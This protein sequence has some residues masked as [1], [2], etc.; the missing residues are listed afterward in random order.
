[1]SEPGHW[2]NPA[3]GAPQQQP[4]YAQAPLPQVAAP[5]TALD[6]APDYWA[7]PAPGPAKIK[8]RGTAVKVT[9]IILLCVLALVTLVTLA[10]FA[11]SIGA[12]VFLI[13]GAMALIPLAICIATL[14]WIDRWEP[15]PK[16]AL[17]LGFCW[18]AGMAVITTLVIGSWVQPLLM[19]TN[20]TADADMVGAVIQAPLVEELCK[21]AGVLLLFFLR[22]RTFDGPIDGV[23]YA[24]MIAAG[25]A[26]TENILYFGQALSESDGAVGGLVG[27]FI[28]RGLMSPFAHVMFTATLGV[29]VG[30]AARNGGT[31]M[32][33]GAWVVGLV[34]AMLLHGLW[35]GTAFLGGNFFVAYVV[36]QVPLFILSIVGIILLRRS[37]AKLTRKRLSDYVPSGWFTQQEVPMLAT[38]S[39]RRRALTW[40]KTFAA[41]PIMKEFIRLATRLAFT[42]QRLL[43]DARGRAGST[44]A[45]R[46]SAGQ[47]LEMALLN[48]ITGVRT[49]L[50]GRHSHAVW[51]AQNVQAQ[52]LQA[53]QLHAQ[54]LQAQNNWHQPR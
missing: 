19:T 1:M 35:N 48:K 49:E 4:Y 32:V 20:P 28:M 40:S 39:G 17:I 37:E 13:C 30:Y 33:L 15:E 9:N 3:A 24:G 41:G 34:P 31:L 45:N 14:M 6:Y 38:G 10:F 16:T 52:Q 47:E 50:L 43:V 25:F 5:R 23:V 36:L 51:Q 11:V 44:A 42:R 46:F 12:N 26:F 54:Q 53:Q 7:H 18:G 22:R 21:G 8:T 27:I 2:Q 29:C